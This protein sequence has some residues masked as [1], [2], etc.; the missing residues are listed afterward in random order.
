MDSDTSV[1][2]CWMAIMNS[3]I[4]KLA[5]LGEADYVCIRL[6]GNGTVSP[7][8]ESSLTSL[9][10]KSTT[11]LPWSPH[12]SLLHYYQHPPSERKNKS[13]VLPLPRLLP[14]LGGVPCPHFNQKEKRNSCAFS[15]NGGFTTSGLL[16]CPLLTASS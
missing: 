15:F 12:F 11:S 7:E 13:R 16:G 14:G 4:W 2:W 1:Y 10:R 5:L 9:P 6:L 3:L 8:G